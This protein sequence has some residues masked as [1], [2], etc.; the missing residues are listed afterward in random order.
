MAALSR[1]R[2]QW[3]RPEEFPG[4]ANLGL[5]NLKSRISPNFRGDC[6]ISILKKNHQIKSMANPLIFFDLAIFFLADLS[7][8]IILVT[9]FNF[10]S[11]F[12]FFYLFFDICLPGSY[13]PHP[14]CN[15][16]LPG[17]IKHVP[18]V[19]YFNMLTYLSLSP[20]LVVM[21]MMAL[22]PTS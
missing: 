21:G 14:F 20:S 2:D 7:G 8:V 17:L 22:K 3:F 9:L 15:L 12:F 13:F 10:S 5:K 18:F 16:W 11:S 4:I 6:N 1:H 19:T